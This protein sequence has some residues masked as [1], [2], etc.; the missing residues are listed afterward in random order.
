MILGTGRQTEV[1][2]EEE[3]KLAGAES[4][5]NEV[6]VQYTGSE[7]QG[8]RNDEVD[9]EA[10]E[11]NKR[12]L[13][14]GGAGAGAEA[15]SESSSGGSGGGSGNFLFDIIRVIFLKLKF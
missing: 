1:N 15:S 6:R 10:D 3:N 4:Q 13:N 9:G 8:F 7:D 2:P 14:F 11:R 5:V 12:Y